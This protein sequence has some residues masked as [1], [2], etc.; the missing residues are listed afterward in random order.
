MRGVDGPVIWARRVRHE[1]ALTRADGASAGTPVGN[2]H[3][4]C[5]DD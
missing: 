4:R 1:A 2:A 5:A 3:R